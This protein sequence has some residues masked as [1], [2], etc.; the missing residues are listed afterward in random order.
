MLQFLWIAMQ[1]EDFNGRSLIPL[2]G[3]ETTNPLG[4]SMART[5][6]FAGVTAFKQTGNSVPKLQTAIFT[7]ST[8]RILWLS[9]TIGRNGLPAWASRGLPET[10]MLTE[11]AVTVPAAQ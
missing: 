8:F 2:T 10:T 5:G 6:V 1:H 4:V 7:L 3:F 9:F 11:N